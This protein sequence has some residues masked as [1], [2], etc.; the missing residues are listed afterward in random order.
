MEFGRVFTESVTVPERLRQL[1]EDAVARLA[2]SMSEIGLQQP[3]TV[4]A[5]NENEA[6]LVAGAHRLAAARRLGWGQI[7]AVLMDASTDERQLWEIDENLMRSEL[8]QAEYSRHVALRKEIYERLH[9]ET[10]HGAIGGGHDQSCHVGDSDKADRFTADTAA[11][12]GKSERSVQRAAQRGEKIAEDVLARIKGTRLDTGKYQDELAKLDH[13]G[14]REKVEA[15]LAQPEPRKPTNAPKRRQQQAED[16]DLSEEAADQVA[17]VLSEYVP[18]EHWDGVKAN[19][20]KCRGKQ[21]AQA[22]DRLTG[23][24]VFDNT[25]GGEAA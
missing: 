4:Y 20:H 5:P 25:R 9:P 18:G 13:E 21:V 3:I 6:E 24:A 23:V 15:D 1:D 2:D 11:K 12:T 10:V 14:Q 7:D 8:S 17:R 22:M 19:L 16:R